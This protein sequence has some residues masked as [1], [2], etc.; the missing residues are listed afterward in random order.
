M[1]LRNIEPRNQNGEEVGVPKYT[2][3]TYERRS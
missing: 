3:L 1:Q 2:Y